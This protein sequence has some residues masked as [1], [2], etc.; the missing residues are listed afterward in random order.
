[1]NCFNDLKKQYPLPIKNTH[2]LLYFRAGQYFETLTQQLDSAEIYYKQSIKAIDTFSTLK[3]KKSEAYSKLSKIRAL[4][5]DFKSAYTFKEKSDSLYNLYF[6]SAQSQNKH[7]FEIKNK[8]AE[9]LNEQKQ[10]IQQ[11][12]LA[13][14]NTKNKLLGLT[15][16]S[17]VLGLSVLIFLVIF[18]FKK[19]VKK[20]RLQHIL[21]KQQQ[22]FE[23]A[24]KEEI[25][26]LKNKE[27][28]SSA[29]Q[30][31]ETENEQEYIKETLEKL[32]LK[33]SNASTIK[34]LLNTLKIDK[35]QK[36][37]AFES[38]FTQINDQFFST[39]K[40]DYPKL[41]QTDLKMLAFIRLG[42]SS[43]EMAQIMGITSEGINTTRSRIRKKM[44]LDRKIALADYLQEI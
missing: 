8:Y 30:L 21:I 4:K 25:L 6:S 16:F 22:D 43:K 13:I 7:L 28:L 39:L 10:Q 41:T 38:R 44:Q 15:I 14:L 3:S 35:T 1:M 11:Q 31:L 9:R 12:Q 32:N 34:S 27:L 26:E 36:W 19:K 2:A 17:I 23:L 5:K 18:F 40:A 29:I 20:E 37:K 24:K 33:G 42:F